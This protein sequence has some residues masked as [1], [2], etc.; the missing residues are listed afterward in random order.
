M[1]WRAEAPS[2]KHNPLAQSLLHFLRPCFTLPL[3][4][5]LLFQIPGLPCVWGKTWCSLLVWGIYWR[6]EARSG[7]H[8]SL[9][10]QQQTESF[11]SSLG[12]LGTPQ[13]RRQ[14]QAVSKQSISAEPATRKHLLRHR[15]QALSQSPFPATH[16]APGTTDHCA[17]VLCCAIRYPLTLPCTVLCTHR[18]LQDSQG[19]CD[20]RVRCVAVRQH[21]LAQ[22]GLGD[23]IK[24]FVSL[25]FQDAHSQKTPLH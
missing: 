5:L 14:L 7:R 17:Q 16:T 13:L 23:P 8:Y 25:V 24:L 4:A 10:R 15:A 11:L 22:N 3:E 9:S 12:P 20:L 6:H 1:V 19:C 21:G 2:H 18:T